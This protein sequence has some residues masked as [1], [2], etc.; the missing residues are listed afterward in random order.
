MSRKIILLFLSE[1]KKVNQSDI[2]T[3]EADEVIKKEY[4]FDHHTEL[5]IVLVDAESKETLDKA[6]I[7][8]AAT[9][10]MG[11]LL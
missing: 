7:K 4:G 1:G 8:R 5:E 2:I 10:D 3:I 9:R 6:A 11:G